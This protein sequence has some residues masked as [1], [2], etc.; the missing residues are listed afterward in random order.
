MSIEIMRRCPLSCPGCYAYSEGHLGAAGPL[1]R[2][3]EFEGAQLIGRVLSLVD[4]HRPLHLS[5]VGGEPLIRWREI[6]ELL[7]AMGRRGISTQVV[8]SAV[9]P[10]PPQWRHARRLNVVVSIDGLQSEHDK[11]RAP[12]TYDRILRHIRGHAITVHC[13]VTRQMTQRAGYL[14]EFADFWAGQP[15]VRKIW[16]SLYTPQV[17]ETS[18]EILPPEV[19][20][21]VIGELSALKDAFPKLEMPTGLL[22]A[23]RRPPSEPGRCIFALTTRTISAD[24]ETVVTPCQLGGKPDCHQCGCIAAAAIEAVGR[25]RLPLGICSGAIYNVSRVVGLCLKT[26]RGVALNAEAL[27]LSGL[28][29]RHCATMIGIRPGDWNRAFRGRQDQ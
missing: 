18:P 22:H 25:H 16:M 21:K 2:L 5:I 11:R 1:S 29:R 19:R 20:E 9:R 13:T 8:T 10:I 28:L 12:A 17:G 7:P 24:L 14:R 3:R 23:Y 15:E 26:L 27:E 6:T 4:H